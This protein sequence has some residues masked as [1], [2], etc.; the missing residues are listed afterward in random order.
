MSDKT[1]EINQANFE[2][3]VV[4]SDVPVLLDFWATWCGPCM[5]IAPILDEV[6]AELGD[7]VK[8]G[9]VNVDKEQTLAMKFGIT[10]IPTLLVFKGGTVQEA[11]VGSRPKAALIELLNKYV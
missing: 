5:A 10:G 11:V 1:F 4:S 2:Q 9:K 6:A 3:E 8:I 7:K